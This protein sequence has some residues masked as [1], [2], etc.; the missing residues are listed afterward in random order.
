MN[1][2]RRFAAAAMMLLTWVNVAGAR[3]LL[4][5]MFQDHAVLQRDRSVRIWGDADPGA[6]VVIAIAGAEVRTRAGA[7]DGKWEAML[8]AQPA[9][10]PHELKVRSSTGATRTVTDVLFGDVWLC[11]GQSNMEMPVRRV[12]NSDVEIAGS[13]NERIRLLSVDR[14]SSSAAR[15]DFMAPVKWQAARS[16]TVDEFSAVCYFLGRDLQAATGAP[17]GLIHSSWGGS[18]VQAWISTSTLSELGGYEDVRSLLAL[19]A[20]SPQQA[21][22]HWRAA[23]Q[24]W[25]SQHD[26]R[27]NG[28]D[29]RALKFDDSSWLT[30]AANRIWEDDGHEEFG[31]FDGIA[32]YRYTVTLTRE[33]AGAATL[34]LGPID[35]FDATWVNGE[36]VGVNDTW[37]LP[38]EYQLARGALKPGKNVIAVAVLD[39]GG[40]GG[41]WGN[42]KQRMLRLASGEALLLDGA[43]RYRPSSPLAQTGVPPRA[44]WG[45][46]QG[47]STLYNAMIAP[48][49]GYTLRGVAWYQGEANVAESAEYARLL[50]AL[51][52]DW[53]KAFGADLPFLVVQLADFGPVAT[54]PV[55]SFWASLRDV[56]RRVVQA[57]PHA[58]LVVAI[59]IGDRYDIHPTNKQQVGRRLALAARR[60][61]YGEDIVASGPT[62][63]DASR[64]ANQVLVRFSKAAAGLVV[65]GGK[66]PIGFELCDE[67]RCEYVDATVQDD[68]VLLEIG[69]I[70]DP[71]R[72]RYG[73]AD[74]PICNLYNENDLP[75]V[76]FEIRIQQ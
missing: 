42:P 5:P 7:Q 15:R 75:A 36:L 4:H 11:S 14:R 52:Q 10:G 72:V 19:H 58:A 28:P 66:R 61:I 24:E 8:P 46:S 43:W 17:Q 37:N 60:M 2:E 32:W 27:H 13:A 59:D 56:Q 71:S 33:Q 3:E 22:Q 53:R 12:V 69:S 63:I 1:Y 31:K 25:W 57:D 49:A 54:R 70:K 35:D 38:R 23:L 65:Y 21:E 55:D 20:R 6:E 30:T 16:G 44:P 73:W 50:P 67:K 74:S 41:L 9:G 62:P 47:T 45:D 34:A 76:P 51:F 39:S 26:P 29:W 18:V 40:G 48:L 64:T 68:R